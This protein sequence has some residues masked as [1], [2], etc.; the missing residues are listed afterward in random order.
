VFPTIDPVDMLNSVEFVGS[1]LV[2]NGTTY[3]VAFVQFVIP[4]T[5][6]CGGVHTVGQLGDTT[7]TICGVEFLL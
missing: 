2:E 3:I 5:D 1:T 7:F 6:S 4:L